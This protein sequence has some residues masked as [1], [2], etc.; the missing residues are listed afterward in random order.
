MEDSK[1][2]S[3]EEL[4]R[5]QLGVENP[6]GLSPFGNWLGGV[7]T[8]YEKGKLEKEYKVRHEMTNALGT[9]HGGAIAS[10]LDEIIGATLISLEY[11]HLKTTVNLVVDYFYPAYENQVLLARGIMIKEGK[12]ISHLQGELYLKENGKLIAR[13]ITNMFTTDI[14]VNLDSLRD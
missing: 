5:S 12:K 3:I 6:K 10:I 14:P 1:P 13:A 9:L 4:F 2:K 8:Y 7:L 11:T